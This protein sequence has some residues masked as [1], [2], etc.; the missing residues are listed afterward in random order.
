M[1]EKFA[2]GFSKALSTAPAL[3][4][5]ACAN[6]APAAIPEGRTGLLWSEYLWEVH[7]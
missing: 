7:S 2:M 5:V 3:R 1:L 6:T 4:R